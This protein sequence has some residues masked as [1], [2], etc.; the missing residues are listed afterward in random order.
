MSLHN[1]LEGEGTPT[2]GSRPETMP[3]LT[4]I[5]VKNTNVK[6]SAQ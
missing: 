2:T 5:Y 6:T 4:K 3:I 1:L